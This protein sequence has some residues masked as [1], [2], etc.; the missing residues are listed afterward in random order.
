MN[1]NKISTYIFSINLVPGLFFL[2]SINIKKAR[3]E[4]MLSFCL[5]FDNFMLVCKR[6]YRIITYGLP[7]LFLN[8]TVINY[9]YGLIYNNSPFFGSQL[10]L[11]FW[12]WKVRN[13]FVDRWLRKVVI[14]QG[15]DIFMR[16]AYTKK[17]DPYGSLHDAWCGPATVPVSPSS[18]SPPCTPGPVSCPGPSWRSPP[19]K[20]T[21]WGGRSW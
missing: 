8:L 6:V 4:V 9:Q 12:S 13:S 18:S 5:N 19:V 17:N 16:R 7:E 20:I 11:T 15:W 10:V 14:H 1:S 3:I 21:L 2:E